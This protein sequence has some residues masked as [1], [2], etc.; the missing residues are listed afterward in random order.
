MPKAPP[1]SYA[2]RLQPI[3]D[4][5]CPVGPDDSGE[6]RRTIIHT[7]AGISTSAGVPDFR[8]PNGVW[9]RELNGLSPPDGTAFGA[10][11]PTRTHFAIN[12]LVAA[13]LV[14]HVVSQNVDGLHVRSGLPRDCISEVHGTAFAEWCSKCEKEWRT[15]D[16]VHT[17]GL[18]KTGNKC[19]DCSAELRDMLC[20]WDSPL[21]DH[22]MDR[23]IEEHRTAT[24]V[25][26]CGH[27]SE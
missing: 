2:A 26:C 18:K 7:G 6:P 13:G 4:K 17:I 16:E 21:P 25:I 22:E 20:D 1:K 19:R 14:R 9:T 23:A 15:E 24:L 10:A 8:G 12:D 5:G 27:R 11:E 3:A